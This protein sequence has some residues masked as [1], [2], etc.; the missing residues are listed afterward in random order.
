MAVCL[1]ALLHQG[2]LS[3]LD[4]HLAE[5]SHSPPHLLAGQG[6][7]VLQLVAMVVAVALPVEEQLL[8]DLLHG[9]QAT[10]VRLLAQCRRGARL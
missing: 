3:S 7:T 5:T 2:H 10:S 1:A 9:P 8:E 4:L 6:R